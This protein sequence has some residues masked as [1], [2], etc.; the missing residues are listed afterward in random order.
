M[1]LAD[2]RPMTI[3]LKHAEPIHWKGRFPG[4]SLTEFPIARAAIEQAIR[5]PS[6]GKNHPWSREDAILDTTCRRSEG[7]SA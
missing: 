1:R 6:C 2:A 4:H 5:C 3:A 7:N